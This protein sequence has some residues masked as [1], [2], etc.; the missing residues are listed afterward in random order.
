MSVFIVQGRAEHLAGLYEDEILQGNHSDFTPCWTCSSTVT[1]GDTM[2]IY[3]MSPVSAIIGQA[4]F[5]S[6]PFMMNDQDSEWFGYRMATY[7]NL[8]IMPQ[9]NF[10]S[11][12]RLKELFPEW[13]W[14]TRPQGAV[15]V[16][17]TY[18]ADLLSF[19]NF[20]VSSQG[21]Q[22]RLF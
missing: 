18:Q 12:R 19:L 22:N 1:K 13:R 9:E 20:E 7:E 6:E 11:L 17:E 2:L 16:P 15:K 5:S 21:N 10:I 14:T 8:K 3:L 4:V